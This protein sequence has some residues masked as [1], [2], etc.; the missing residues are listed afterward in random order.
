MILYI[1]TII[2]C[3]KKRHFMYRS[4]KT[5]WALYGG[6]IIGESAIKKLND[7]GPKVA[8]VYQIFND[9]PWKVTKLNVVIAWPFEVANDK[10]HGKWLLYLEDTPIVQG[11]LTKLIRVFLFSNTIPHR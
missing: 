7:V 9:G 1:S 10:I 5:Q 2:A 8:H 6:P 11:N 4:A 3:I